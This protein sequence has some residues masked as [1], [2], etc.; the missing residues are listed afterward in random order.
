MTNVMNPVLDCSLV[1]M[2][3]PTFKTYMLPK[4]PPESC[5]IKPETVIWKTNN[6]TVDDFSKL[7]ELQSTTLWACKI[8]IPMS[9][10]NGRPIFYISAEDW[11]AIYLTWL[12]WL[13]L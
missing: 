1:K 7:S 6:K 11:D 4:M 12:Y 3:F 8:L 2:K 9:D 10:E 5:S 13:T